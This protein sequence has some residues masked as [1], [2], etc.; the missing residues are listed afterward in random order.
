MSNFDFKHIVRTTKDQVRATKDD[1]IRHIFKNTRFVEAIQ[2]PKSIIRLLTKSSFDDIDS[3]PI[4]F[5]NPGLFAECKS[6][7]CNLCNKGYI[8]E[9]TSFLTSNNFRWYIKSH[10]NCY[11]KDVLYFL[12]CNMCKSDKPESNTGKTWTDFRTRLNN[13]ISDCRTGRTTDLFD[14]H[15]HECGKRNNCLKA[16]YFKVY[17]YMKLST[18]DKLLAYEKYLHSRKFDTINK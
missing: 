1:T 2:Q 12:V 5:R 6:N 15:V 14:I 17:A 18:P 4:T 7:R 11:S 9:C 13:H 3:N 10:I 16:P 8:Q